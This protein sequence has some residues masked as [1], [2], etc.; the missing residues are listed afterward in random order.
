MHVANDVAV[1]AT[2][3]LPALQLTHVKFDRALDATDA[4]LEARTGPAMVVQAETSLEAS[5]KTPPDHV[6]AADMSAEQFEQDEMLFPRPPLHSSS[7][8]PPT[9]PVV[10]THWIATAAA[11]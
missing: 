9:P 4:S 7:E 10:L 6:W 11:N 2:Q 8:D 3:N 1:C 5:S